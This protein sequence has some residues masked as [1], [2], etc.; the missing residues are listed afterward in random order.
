MANILNRSPRHAAFTIIE[1]LVVIAIIGVLVTLLLPA[2]QSAREAARRTQCANRLKQIALATLN[3]EASIGLLPPSGIIRR[4]HDAEFDVEVFNP[5]GGVQIGWGVLILPYLEGSALADRF[6]VSIQLA[7]QPSDGPERYAAEYTCPSDEAAGRVFR[8]TV[9][10]RGRPFA[11]GNYAAFSSPFHLDLQQ[12][13][14]GALIDGGQRTAAIEDGAG[15][16]LAF[17]EVRTRDDEADER[18]VWAAPWS[19]ASLLAFDMHPA[20]WRIEHD[21]TGAG[22]GYAAE[23]HAVYTA[24]PESVGETQ[25]PNAQSPNGD[26]LR[27]CDAAQQAAS[28]ADRMPCVKWNGT[29]GVR[30]YLSAAPRS[31]HPGGV[32]SAFVDGH[33]VFLPNGVDDFAMAYAVSVNDGQSLRPAR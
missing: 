6:D 4:H 23:D 16:T 31:L 22:D 15:H 24:S 9:L 7:F 13:Y 17:S 19:G 26:V 1:L 5:F 25:R 28:A 18:G 30:G 12:L 2:V 29:L 21:G 11:K 33:V 3:Y 20:G 27:K 10:T 32:N 14:R 8:H